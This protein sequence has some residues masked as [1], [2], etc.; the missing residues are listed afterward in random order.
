[1]ATLD[2]FIR[3]TF[4]RSHRSGN[5]IDG[6][7]GIDYSRAQNSQ[8][9]S[10]YFMTE[11]ICARIEVSG[12]SLN[13]IALM[14]SWITLV[15]MIYAL[16]L[17]LQT[18]A[19]ATT[20]SSHQKIDETEGGFTGHLDI[21]DNFGRAVTSLGDLDD[22]GVAD[23]AVGAPGDDD[24]GNFRGA[25][26][27]LFLN[28]DGT[29]K[30]HQKISDVKGDFTGALKGGD[31]FGSSLTSLGDLDGDDVVDLA[32][33]AP[34]D[35]D[36]G[37]GRGAVWLLFLRSNGGV[38][39]HQKIS[40]TRGDFTGT[41]N[42][43]DNFGA[44][45]AS[46]SDLDGDTVREL[47][48]GASGDSATGQL[49]TGAVW[50]VFM[51]ADGRAKG[52]QKING[53]EGNFD[54]TL[55]SF[56]AFGR[57][58]TSIGDINGDNVTDLAVGADG[59]GYRGSVWILF[60]KTDGTVKGHSKIGHGQGGFTGTIDLL[61]RFGAAITSVGDLNNDA[62]S[63]LVVGQPGDPDEGAVWLLL[64]DTD[65]KVIDHQK[66]DDTKGGFTGDLNEYDKFGSALTWISD[67]S[68]ESAGALIVGA[69]GDDGAHSATFTGAVWLLF[70]CKDLP[71]HGGQVAGDC[72]EQAK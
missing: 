28:K 54:G 66:F 67:F 36:G 7:K 41:L 47:V 48:V 46:I 37:G 60:L 10:E 63:D 53:S 23:I 6:W 19:H 59:D 24:G 1:M 15:G 69:E 30:R 71:D 56:D 3:A 33:G 64:L 38:K 9:G 17:I 51:Q 45:V 35:D 65:G 40:D 5:Q 31:R 4:C 13:Y 34:G 43:G 14:V 26:W 42:D 21:R 49:R 62:V 27:I 72:S 52:H 12:K 68:N 44:A 22:D 57:S 25:V 20:F 16:T 50:L 29:V 61:H 11:R 39:G 8:D 32:V 18:V 70:A 2:K 55:R 58:L